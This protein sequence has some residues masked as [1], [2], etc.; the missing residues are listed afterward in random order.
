MSRPDESHSGPDEPDVN[1]NC[2]PCPLI[3][4][5]A[6]GQGYDLG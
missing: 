6:G 5:S 4:K 1:N 3:G 2:S